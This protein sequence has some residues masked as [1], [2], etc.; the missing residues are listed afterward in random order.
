MQA[1]VG[2]GIHRA[3][4]AA[5]LPDGPHPV[6]ADDVQRID[7]LAFVSLRFSDALALAAVFTTPI[8]F[9]DE[10]EF[11]I[12]PAAGRI[13]FRS[14]SQLGLF[15]FAKNRSRMTAFAARFEQQTRR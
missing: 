9:R 7:Q 4:F 13:D 10:L 14:R 15:D 1:R 2:A 11:R 5:K 12:D 6:R 8:G 3:N